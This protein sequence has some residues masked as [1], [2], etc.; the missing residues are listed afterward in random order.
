MTPTKAERARFQAL[1]TIG[2]VACRKNGVFSQADV[3]H[4]LSG[5]GR[6]RGHSFTIPLCPWHHRGQPPGDLAVRT[7]TLVYGPSLARSP[8]KFREVFGTDEELLAQTDL[9][10]GMLK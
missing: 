6:R 9:L 8:R 1:Q 10:V 7:S 5:G 4:L 2:C 3:H